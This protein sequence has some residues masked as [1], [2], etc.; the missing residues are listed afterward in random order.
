MFHLRKR[1]YR[2]A[3]NR[4]SLTQ[5]RAFSPSLI[6]YTAMQ[7]RA[8]SPFVSANQRYSQTLVS[9]LS[10][11][12]SLSLLCDSE[13]N[14]LSASVLLGRRRTKS[15]PFTRGNRQTL[16]CAERC[17]RAV[18][19]KSARGERIAVVVESVSLDSALVKR[20]VRWD[21]E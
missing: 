15:A 16:L 2:T 19:Y 20:I 13:Y 5:F 12:L 21:G 1:V 11:Y 9:S 3:I 8:N 6:H 7:T 10:L 4:P 14:A 17:A 18:I